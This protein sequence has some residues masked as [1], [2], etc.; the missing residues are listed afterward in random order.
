MEKSRKTNKLILVLLLLLIAGLSIGF[1]AFDKNL[2]I[3]FSQSTVKP[4]KEGF[5]VVFSSSN[6]DVATDAIVPSKSEDSVTGTNAN[7]SGTTLSGLSAVFQKPGQSVTWEV[8]AYN[9]GKYDAFFNDITLG[10]ITC[11]AVE[12]T[13]QSKVDIA[14]TGLVLTVTVGGET[15]SI[16]GAETTGKTETPAAEH[17]LK[18]NNGEKV[19]VKLEFNANASNTLADGDFNVTIGDIVLGYDSVNTVTAD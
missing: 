8:Y 16:T 19:T 6:S 14:A 10:K 11:T 5:S 13:D 4:D 9:D 3:S 12:G 15:F 18:I 17:K 7:I 2:T 1:A